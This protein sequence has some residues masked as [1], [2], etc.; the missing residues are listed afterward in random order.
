VAAGSVAADA[1]NKGQVDAAETAAKAR[2]NHTGE[3]AIAT[4]TGLQTAL[5]AKLESVDYA[6]LP[7]GTTLTVIKDGTWPARPTSR[8][9][10]IV[11][12]KGADP[13]PAIV[14]SGTGGMLDEVDYRL[15]TP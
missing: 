14:T 11:A 13:S 1:A 4:V 5:D 9:D 2:A 7:A 8:A 6:D 15:V 10:I 12:W 3:Q